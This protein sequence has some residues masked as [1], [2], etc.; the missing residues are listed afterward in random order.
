MNEVSARD[1]SDFTLSRFDILRLPKNNLGMGEGRLVHIRHRFKGGGLLV[2][3]FSNPWEYLLT[4]AGGMPLCSREC[5]L[6]E[7]H[8]NGNRENVKRRVKAIIRRC[9]LFDVVAH[10]G[11]LERRETMDEIFALYVQRTKGY[12]E[13]RLRSSSGHERLALTALLHPIEQQ[14]EIGMPTPLPRQVPD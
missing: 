5:F 2:S 13:E 11:S 12:L 4:D 10:R 8:L 3:P 9:G 1:L 6:W 7:E 14:A